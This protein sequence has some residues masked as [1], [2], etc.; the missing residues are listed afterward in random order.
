MRRTTLLAALAIPLLLLTGCSAAAESDGAGSDAGSAP[1]HVMPDG[2]VMDGAEH[3]DHDSPEPS[4]GPSEAARM[5]CAGE[6]TDAIAGMFELEDSIPVT[7]SWASPMFTCTYD[8]KGSPLVLT[9][10]DATDETEGEQHFAEV[11]QSYPTATKID[12]M[13]SLGLPSFATGDGIV[14]FV[15]DGKT[16][17]VDATKLPVGVGADPTQTPAESAYAVASAVL[18]CWTHHT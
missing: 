8:I 12:G 2:S 9:V 6:V 7:S 4:E 14:S 15:R 10:Y 1:T 3:E 5:V 16:L 18:V 13:A 17:L 11:E